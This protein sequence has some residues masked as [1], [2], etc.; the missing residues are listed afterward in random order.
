MEPSVS[1]QASISSTNQEV[2]PSCGTGRFIVVLKN[3]RYR[4]FFRAR[5]IQSMVIYVFCY[6]IFM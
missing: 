1:G 5:L 2:P 4:P 3:A 6:Q